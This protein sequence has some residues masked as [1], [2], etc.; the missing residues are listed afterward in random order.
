M[1]VADEERGVAR[2]GRDPEHDEDQAQRSGAAPALP[3]DPI[4]SLRRCAD[5]EAECK[6][7]QVEVPDGRT[8][9]AG[10]PVLVRW[11]F[12]LAITLAT[13]NMGI[14]TRIPF[15]YYRF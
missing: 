7:G 4:E 15:I 10:R 11:S 12:Y 1:A 9:M 6:R 8:L 14:S 2:L 3:P 13:M 5:Q